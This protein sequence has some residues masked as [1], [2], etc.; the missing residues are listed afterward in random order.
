MRL[1]ISFRWCVFALA[2]VAVTVVWGAYAQV[3]RSVLEAQTREAVAKA[4]VMVRA[5]AKSTHRA[6][7]E[8]DITLRSLALEF[9]ESGLP[10]IRRFL[11]QTLYDP[12]LIHH[13]TVLDADG[14]V[15]F[16][17]EGPGVPANQRDETA[18][19]FHQGTGRDLMHIGTP[20]P[21]ATNGGPLLRLSR[22]LTGPDGGFAG[23]VIANI[24]PDV[25]G[26]FYQ[27]ANLGPQGVATLIG[28]D[29]VIRARGARHDAEAVGLTIPHSRL[30][31]ELRRSLVG[32]YWQES[33]TDGVLRAFAYRMVENYP[34]VA[35]IGVAEEDIE[36]S[37]A[38][39]RRTLFLLAAILTASILLVSLFLLVQHRTAERLRAALTLNRNFLARVSH[40]LRTPL[41]AIIGF[42]EVIRDQMLGPQ[43]GG[44]YADYARDIHD[45]GRH[46]LGLINDI[47]D[48]SRLQAGTL[49]L[50]PENLD[51]APVV[52]WA[53]RMVAPQADAKR[54]RLD[55]NVEPG[56][57]SVSA[58]ERA[59]KQ[60]L[61]NLLTNAVTFTPDAGRILVTV[62]GG[63]EGGCRV[64]V[65]DNGIGM[66]P[67]QL[68]QATVP[69][70]QPEVHVAQPGQG[71]GLGLSIVK[72][73][74]EAHG[75][76]L[77]IDSRPGEGSQF[78]L[79][80]AA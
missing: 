34:L 80:F 72:S 14:T 42:S 41:N 64:R 26:E 60:M 74:M 51:V 27:Q 28:L 31:E 55:L 25:L 75:G 29:K 63:A 35:A 70:G 59:L 71:C 9:G 66:T 12:T 50:R 73:L 30:W 2:A 61:L 53:F 8:V 44:R 33:K 58:D 19:A 32:V 39:L 22:R 62:S 56:S 38:D 36:A 15:L 78:T 76:R 37:M 47:M 20:F 6:V 77:H 43:A 17:S 16:R 57:H 68:H 69:F 18:F 52:E 46:L 54:I 49:P 11:D 13:F 67:E 7:H 5:F 40:E 21:G 3:V 23:V 48:L 65:V 1:P 45:S 24:D 4:E 79:D 10:G